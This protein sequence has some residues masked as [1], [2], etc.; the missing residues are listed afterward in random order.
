[1]HDTREFSHV[2]NDAPCMYTITYALKRS[3]SDVRGHH[4]RLDQ[5]QFFRVLFEYRVLFVVFYQI[6]HWAKLL[7]SNPVHTVNHIHPEMLVSV[8]RF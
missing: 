4:E 8:G 6:L 7:L 3:D 2:C 5:V 1:M